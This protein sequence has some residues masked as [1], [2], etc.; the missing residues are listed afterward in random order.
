MSLKVKARSLFRNLFRSRHV[1]ADLDQEIH[2]H[3]DLLVDEN[4]RA[5]MPPKEALRAAWLELGGIDQVKDKVRADRMGNWLRSVLSD[6]RYALRQLRSIPGFTAIA[7]LTLALGVGAN[8]AIF[9]FSDAILL[10]PLPVIRP[11]EVLTVA[12]ATPDKALE[13]LSFPDYID[14]R[15]NSTSFS[16]LLAYRLDDARHW[17]YAEMRH[18]RCAPR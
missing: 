1:E 18:L 7:I 10:R 5:G 6:C 14:I 4:I 11:A 9:S 12:D 8:T 13:G 3:L 16:A 15:D 17:S 2:S